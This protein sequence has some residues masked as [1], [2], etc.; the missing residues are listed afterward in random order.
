MGHEM[1]SQPVNRQFRVSY[2]AGW[3]GA[4]SGESQGSALERTMSAMN[5]QGY[6]VVFIVADRWNI[7]KTIL[8]VVIAVCTLGAWYRAPNHIIVGERVK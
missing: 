6:R 7:F 5:E 2:R 8:N 4:L 1:I 3:I